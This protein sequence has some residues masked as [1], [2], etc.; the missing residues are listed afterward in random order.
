MPWPVVPSIPDCETNAL[1]GITKQGNKKINL[2]PPFFVRDKNLKFI[3]RTKI[4]WGV[5]VACT[6]SL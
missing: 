6:A 5:L 4:C 1:F 2:C 3:T